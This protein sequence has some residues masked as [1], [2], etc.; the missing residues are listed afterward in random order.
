MALLWPLPTSKTIFVID[1]VGDPLIWL[2]IPNKENGHITFQNQSWG[3][4]VK[5]GQ[6]EGSLLKWS[7]RPSQLYPLYKLLDLECLIYF[8]RGP[9]SPYHMSIWCLVLATNL[10][11]LK[12]RCSKQEDWP[13]KAPWT[14]YGAQPLQDD[15]N[16]FQRGFQ[17]TN[18]EANEIGECL[19]FPYL[20][21]ED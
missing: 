3:T 1:Q 7:L 12:Y 8:E 14:L 5:R 18:C 16:F 20:L 9:I 21:K 4:K 13:H 15:F 10:P 17:K 11:K 2:A 6:C 19:W